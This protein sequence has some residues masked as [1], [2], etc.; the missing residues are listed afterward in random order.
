MVISISLVDQQV[1]DDISS[2][3]Q[4]ILSNFYIINRDILAEF[5]DDISN[6]FMETY[7][8]GDNYKGINIPIY[9]SFPDT[10]PKSA[11]LLVQYEGGEE[12]TDLSSLGLIV[13]N[14]QANGSMSTI[15]ELL[16]VQVDNSGSEPVAYLQTSQNI[17]SVLSV[18]QT[19]NYTSKDNKIYLKYVDSYK[20]D[21]VY[22]DVY[23]SPL[24]DASGFHTP[25]GIVMNDKVTVAII[26]SNVNTVRCLSA[27]MAY[28][29]IYLKTRLENNGN[30]FL[31]KISF[32]GMDLI[33]S[34]NSGD[35]S[36]SGQQLR[37]RRMEISYKTTQSV[38]INSTNVLS[39]IGMKE[40]ELSNG[41]S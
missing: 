35:D 28:I 21:D 10:V 24:S 13:G 33:E 38:G 39:D 2:L 37:Y 36:I 11:F 22:M 34:V 20:T 15:H 8:I 26:S 41:N 32:N 14:R 29:S 17:S 19:T 30:V 12:D 6:A 31:P 5:P 23:Y 16:K 9:F 1:S 40:G 18:V 27:I 7:G 4:G 3:L 25:T